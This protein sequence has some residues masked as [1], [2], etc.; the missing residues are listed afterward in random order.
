MQRFRVARPEVPHRDRV[1]QVGAGVALLRVDEVGELERIAHEEHRGV[2]ADH[3][4][5]AFIGI[6]LDRE[7]AHVALG[8]GGA[9]LAGD[10]READEQRR[11]LADLGK[12][13]GLGVFRDV[14]RDPERAVG[15]GALGMHAA[16][17]NDFTVEVGQFFEEPDILQQHRAARA[18]RLRVLVIGN[19]CAGCRGESVLLAHLFLLLWVGWKRSPRQFAA[20]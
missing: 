19:G 2:V 4:P 7:P 20:A 12:D 17:G 18:C 11:F 8:I 1:A 3:V 16:L 15:T 6:E 9:T 10:G 14:V 5:V 13:R